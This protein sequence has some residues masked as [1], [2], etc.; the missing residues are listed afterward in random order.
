MCSSDLDWTDIETEARE[1]G[2]TGF[3]SKPLFPSDLQRVLLQACGKPAPD[4]GG[5]AER[6]YPL[7]GKKVLMVD[8]SALN[9]KVG[10]LLL[11]EQGM[12]VETAD[13]G[14]VALDTIREKGTS[15]YDFV[16]MDVQMPV[17]DGYQATAAIR[18]L[19]GGTALKIGEF[20][21][22]LQRFAV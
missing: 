4:R 15:Y 2:V 16:V 11:R 3:I 10:V 1:A 8:D 14:Q 7:K 9:L 17:M 12:S 22:E 18:K 5:R 13:N 6:T 19:P 21:A 20:V